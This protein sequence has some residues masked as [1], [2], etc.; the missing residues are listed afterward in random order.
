MAVNKPRRRFYTTYR[1]A[2][3][4]NRTHELLETI[5]TLSA[6]RDRLA[7][8]TSLARLAH[9]VVRPGAAATWRRTVDEGVE[10]W[11][12][13]YQVRKSAA[14]GGLAVRRLSMLP[15]AMPDWQGIEG[16]SCA[17][18]MSAFRPRELIQCIAREMSGLARMFHECRTGWVGRAVWAG[19]RAI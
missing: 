10:Q 4:P 8:T 18:K 17:T 2:Q 14:P 6:V 3:P 9:E 16:Q 15:V 5:S 11:V 12:L 19:H 1:A 7:L 13:V